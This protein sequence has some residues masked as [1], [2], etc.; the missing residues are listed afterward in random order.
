M[1][2]SAPIERVRRE[3]TRGLL[4]V[5]PTGREAGT[6]TA[7]V[8]GPND[9]PKVGD[10]VVLVALPPGLIEGLPEQD[11]RAISAMVGQPVLLVGFDDFGRAQLQ[12]DDPFDARPGRHNHT[13]TIWVAPQF[14]S[15]QR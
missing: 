3:M 10:K 9:K 1:A 8:T 6:I 11:Q 5:L 13:H 15:V 14:I 4:A 7:S 12:F 2:A